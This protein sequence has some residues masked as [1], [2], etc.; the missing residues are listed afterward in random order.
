MLKPL[1]TMYT[2]Q[3]WA[4]LSPIL[5]AS[6]WGSPVNAIAHLWW[7]SVFGSDDCL[8]LS[9]TKPLPE[10]MLTLIY[11][12]TQPQWINSCLSDHYKCLH[13]MMSCCMQNLLL[14]VSIWMKLKKI[15][16][17]QITIANLWRWNGSVLTDY[18]VASI[19]PW[20][21]KFELTKYR[22]WCM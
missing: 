10:P 5:L 22:C 15:C 2:C 3:N 14:S 4:R 21:S 1:P 19:P 8:V 17:I 9:G 18:N 11:G 16:Q 12:I 20:K 6:V 7:W 13:V